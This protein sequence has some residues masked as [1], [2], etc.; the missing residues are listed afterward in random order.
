MRKKSVSEVHLIFLGGG[1][2]VH[3]LTPFPRAFYKQLPAS[4]NPPHLVP[5]SL[6]QVRGVWGRERARARARERERES[7]RESERDRTEVVSVASR[8]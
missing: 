8:A 1:I 5:E 3:L 6:Q 4:P 7:E 2:R